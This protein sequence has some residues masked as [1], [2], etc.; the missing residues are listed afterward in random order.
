MRAHG[1]SRLS[2]HGH[3]DELI[4][5]R[6]KTLTLIDVHRNQYRQRTGRELTDEN[7]RI[8]E[9]RREV[10]SLGAIIERLRTDTAVSEEG[11]S[12][13]GA[14]TANLLPLVQIKARASHQSV[15]RKADPGSTIRAV[16]SACSRWETASSRPTANL[17][18]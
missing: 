16:R 4:D 3:L 18:R 14:G 12:G 13:G 7:V 8:H 5:Q 2:C 1:A 17:D 6:S 15:L 9:R 10:A 11:N